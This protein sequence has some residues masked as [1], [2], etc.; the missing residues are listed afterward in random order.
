MPGF[1]DRMRQR[2]KQSCDDDHQP[3]PN[4]SRYTRHTSEE[5]SD[6]RLRAFESDLFALA[7]DEDVRSARHQLTLLDGGDLIDPSTG[8][9]L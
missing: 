1:I 8:E 2:L 5:A 6:Q 7:L 4:R 9:V 3:W